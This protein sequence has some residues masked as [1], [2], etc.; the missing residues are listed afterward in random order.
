MLPTILEKLSLQ[1]ELRVQLLVPP[2]HLILDPLLTL[3]TKPG[4]VRIR[5]QTVTVLR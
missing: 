2:G 5:D 4:R 1:A 3:G